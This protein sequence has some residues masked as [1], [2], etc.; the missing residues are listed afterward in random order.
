MKKYNFTDMKNSMHGMANGFSLKKYVLAGCLFV[1]LLVAAPLN[2]VQNYYVST[3]GNGSGTSTSDYASLST[4]TSTIL[5]SITSAGDKNYVINFA[6]GTY[7]VSSSF[8]LNTT[9]YRGAN[10]TFQRYGTTGTVT[11]NNTGSNIPFVTYYAGSAAAGRIALT[12]KNVTVQN[13]SRTTATLVGTAIAYL[14]DYNDLTLEDCIVQNNSPSTNAYYLFAN[15]SANASMTFKNTQ[16]LNNTRSGMIYSTA[17]A[18][19]TI[20]SVEGCTFSGNGGSSTTVSMIYNYLSAFT[21]LNDCVFS[22]NNT[23]A[24]L[25]NSTYTANPMLVERTQ[26][27]GNTSR[28]TRILSI[29]AALTL[30]DSKFQGNTSATTMLYTPLALTMNRDTISGNTASDVYLIYSA[31]ASNSTIANSYFSSNSIGSTTGASI[32][33]SAGT[34]TNTI[35]N[36]IFKSNSSTGTNSATIYLA[37]G[38]S[39]IYNNYFEGNS[40]SGA[41]SGIIYY[42]AGTSYTYQNTFYNNTSSGSS[43][44]TLRLVAGTPYVYNNT[45][46]QN[47]GTGLFLT[48]TNSTILNNTFYNSQSG[49]GNLYIYG[50]QA[51]SV[52]RNN[53]LIGSYIN[54]STATAGGYCSYNISGGRYYEGAVPSGGLTGGTTL[55]D[56]LSCFDTNLTYFD[57]NLPPIH[58]VLNLNDANNAILRKGDIGSYSSYI[59]RDQREILRPTYVPI[60]AGSI[61]YNR[62]V[63]PSAVNILYIY[64]PADGLFNYS[65]DFSQYIAKD[66]SVDL[67]SISITF[68]PLSIGTLTPNGTSNYIYNFRPNNDGTRPDA[69]ILNDKTTINYTVSY[70]SGGVTYYMTNTLTIQ[71]VDLG[72]EPPIPGLEDPTG[73]CFG[74]MGTITFTSDEI[75]RNSTVFVGFTIPLVGDLNGDGFPEIVALSGAGESATAITIV[76]GRDGTTL[77]STAIFT[78]AQGWHCTPSSIALVDADRNGLGEVIVAYPPA[79][80]TLGGYLASYEITSP[81]DF[82]LV[83]KWSSSAQFSSV[84]TM[85]KPIPQ[86]LDFDGDSNPEVMAYNRIFDATTGNLKMTLETL[87]F[88]DNETSAFVGKDMNARAAGSNDRTINFSYTYDLDLDGV[89]DIAAGGK[90]YYELNIN[91]ASSTTASVTGTDFKIARM[92]GVPDGRTSVAD[93][94]GDGIPDVVVMYKT[95][96]TTMNVVVWN[97]DLLRIVG[98]QVMRYNN[99]TSPWTPVSYVMGTETMTVGVGAGTGSGSYVYIGDID[100]I[101]DVNTGKLLPEIAVLT[102]RITASSVTVHPNVAG[103]LTPNGSYYG[104]SDASYGVIFGLTWDEN[105]SGT[106]DRLKL[107]FILEH[108]DTSINTGFTMFDFDNDGLQ[109]ICYRGIQYL[110]IIKANK[111]YIFRTETVG[112]GSILFQQTVSSYTGFEYPSIADINGDNSADMIVMGDGGYDGDVIGVGTNGY[113]FAPALPVWN[114]FMYSP[115]KIND[116]LTTPIGPAR[117]PLEIVY[118]RDIGGNQ[119]DYQ[120]FNGSLIQAPHYMEEVRNGHTYMEPILYYFDGYIVDP[121]ISGTTITFRVGNKKGMKTTITSNTPVRI[122]QTSVVGS[123]WSAKYTL[124]ALGLTKAIEGGAVSDVL[125]ITGVPDA[126]GVYYLRLGDD[127]DNVTGATPDWSY[128]TNGEAGDIPADPSSGI[129]VARRYFRDC[130]WSDNESIIA[131]FV[132]VNDFATI[133]EYDSIMVDIFD[134]D[135]IPADLNPSAD[136]SIITK[137][138]TAGKLSY[139]GNQLRYTHVGDKLLVNNIDTITYSLT[140]TDPDLGS[141][142][143]LSANVYIYVMQSDNGGFVTCYNETTDIVIKALPA[144]TV[145]NWYGSDGTTPL[146]TG[147]TSLQ[148]TLTSDSIFKVKPVMPAGYTSLNFPLGTLKVSVATSGLGDIAVLKWTGR[149]NTDWSNPN[150]WTDENGSPVAYAP[151]SCVDVILPEGL[152]NYPSLIKNG[153]VRDVEIENRAMIANT[154]YLRYRAASMEIFF[155]PV[156]S[157]RDRWVMYSAPFGK[158]YS[159]DFMLRGNDGYP[160]RGA[161]YMSFFQQANPDNVA[162]TATVY[163]FTRSF[164]NVEQELTLGRGFILKIDSNVD[165]VTSYNFPSK[166][167]QYEYYYKN[168]WNENLPDP[169]LSAVLSRLGTKPD[170]LMNAR[171]ITEM[172][173]NADANG[174]F[175]LTLPGDMG[176]S[177]LLM[178]T[179]PFNAYLDVTK[180]FAAN[181]GLNSSAY[182]IWG[183]TPVS[184]FIAFQQVGKKWVVSTPGYITS[185]GSAGNYIAPHQSFFVLKTGT[186]Q[187]SVTFAPSMT[188]TVAT[189]GSDYILRNATASSVVTTDAMYVSAA[190]NGSTST[191][192]VVATTENVSAAKVFLNDAEAVVDIYSLNANGK[193]M[194]LNGISDFSKETKLGIRLRASGE[195]QFAFAGLDNIEGY[196]VFLKDG[197]KLYPVSEGT[198]YKLAVQGAAAANGYFEVNDRFSLVFVKKP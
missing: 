156:N 42:A 22:N 93:I 125:T 177:N 135:I 61:D 181:T 35:N 122:Y 68:D 18:T 108:E 152:T 58:D 196:N 110:R 44:A 30:I 178:V 121:H 26:F 1:G 87:A 95:D 182:Y 2:A 155:D 163:Q 130:D 62:L 127:S 114:Q 20:L 173:T 186:A 89:Y 43:A 59:S 77:K 137:Q 64:R 165:A 129:G 150:N 75:L 90:V 69:N 13:Y 82:S 106:T 15:P 162:E 23:S 159:G 9:A 66:A 45:L 184:G 85:N 74:T 123:A 113:K 32:I 5:P 120:P 46:S 198:R 65:I 60:S 194:S 105:A 154:H 98:G 84:T 10:V 146:A 50:T 81:T 96:A 167:D 47:S 128:G 112:N 103:T 160:L 172:A 187:T 124:G 131:K 8:L 176:G 21:S 116:D 141:S 134:N 24:T 25:V 79:T 86:V 67:N 148:V 38:T 169:P 76:D 136:A 119:V 100:G 83:R 14:Y 48:T 91:N 56:L 36:N 94:N 78:I 166:D 31:S 39:R 80:V 145:F 195:V 164:S 197:E 37:A 97:P 133:Q 55:T 27:I 33:R 92:T 28:S 188:Y 29:S 6:P 109:E 7:N 153:L 111:P 72:V 175:S 189:G 139:V 158:M 51:G 88:N 63:Y 11:F 19:T 49:V 157:E 138:P 126:Y 70:V 161:A 73:Q 52:V 132:L 144:G 185:N 102:G 142:K 190:V 118:T 115:F 170:T 180:F 117:N 104:P 12:L 53:L 193:A 40:S 4:L 168:L 149:V 191:T 54:P 34:G 101:P 192:S 3:T 71:V 107:S 151:T 179:N 140:Y 17:S 57:P 99:A 16:F 143:T 41:T 183:G 171:F 147:T 174:R